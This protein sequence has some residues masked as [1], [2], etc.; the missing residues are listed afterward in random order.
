MNDFP[1]P[2]KEHIGG[3][4]IFR[5]IP[6]SSVIAIPDKKEF[7]FLEMQL[8]SNAVWYNGVAS[9]RSLSFS[10]NLA[11]NENGDFYENS[12]SAFYP[13]Q[14]RELETLFDEMVNG[15]FLLRIRDYE[16]N[17]RLLGTIEDPLRF[18][19]SY[20]SA[21]L[22]GSKGYR[23]TFRNRQ[24]SASKFINDIGSEAALRINTDGQLEVLETIVNHSFSLNANGELVVTGPFDYKFYLN[25]AGQLVFDEF[26]TE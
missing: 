8:V 6:V 12:I 21:Q 15:E 23:I 25:S 2:S 1:T 10:D 5:F 13:G 20:D 26:R 7:N 3:L 14:N 19:R 17:E 24:L 11:G 16:G 4:K 22:G 18:T 9:F